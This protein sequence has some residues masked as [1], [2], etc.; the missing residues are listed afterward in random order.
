MPITTV[1]SLREH[2]QTAIELEHS[3]IPPY[4]CALYSIHDG[5][6]QYAV[7][8]VQSVFIEE[9]LHL[10]LAANLLN[11]IGGEPVLDDPQLLAPHPAYLPHSDE[12]FQV[13]L[14]AFTPEA[15]DAFMAIERPASSDSPPEDDRYETIGQFYAAVSVA[16]DELAEQLGEAVLF[17]GDPCRQVTDKI[18]YGGAGRII[19]VIDLESARAALKEIVEQGEGLDHQAVFDGDHNMFHPERDEV[20]HYFRFVELRDGKSFEAGNTPASGP[21]GEPVDVDWDAV[22][23]MRPNPSSADHAP[24]SD[25]RTAMEAFNRTYCTILDLLQQSFNGNPSLLAVATGEMYGLKAQ[26]LDL[27]TMPI[28]ETGQTAGPSFEWIPPAER[29]P[30]N[31]SI[32]VT[33][34]GPYLVQGTIE[35][36]DASGHAVATSGVWCLCRCGGSRSKPFC[37]GTHATFDF[38]GTETADHGDIADRR[39]TYIANDQLTIYDDRTRCAHFG[40]CTDR[41]PDVFGGDPRFVEPGTTD[42][43]LV[44]D[45]VVSRCPSG[46]L[47]YATGHDLRP[48]EIT[49]SPAVKP[50]VDGPY[51][52]V[53]SLQVTASDPEPYEIRHRQTLCRCGQSANKPFCDGSHWYAGFRDPLPPELEN[54]DTLPWTDP[55]AAKRG[56][57]RHAQGL[58]P[59]QPAKQSQ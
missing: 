22:H 34:G 57:Q 46:A 36:D 55:D 53:G 8:V 25:I 3:T 59:Q 15:V 23:P 32:S 12:S 47:A 19:E 51:Q 58:P 17:S 18:F 42:P 1:E 4:L 45:V 5:T 41:L 6:N 7:E 50:I 14:L 54:A 28:G 11:A 16:F 9:M 43:D 49:R 35:I 27:M 24:D 39:D 52:V 48:V 10:T 30:T 29:D 13:S 26:A 40:Q 20:A 56:R 44:A 21:T 2:L 33:R 37:D 38:D 31:A